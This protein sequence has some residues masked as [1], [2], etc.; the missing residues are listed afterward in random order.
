[1]YNHFY[2]TAV[3]ETGHDILRAWVARMLMLGLHITGKVPFKTIFLH[4]LVRDKHGQKMSKSKGNVVN[5]LEVIQTY[6]AD[7]LRASLMFETKEGSDVV[8]T[9]EKMIGMRN[10]GNKLWNIGRFIFMNKVDSRQSVVEIQERKTGS[11]TLK[12]KNKTLIK[13]EKELAEVKVKYHKNMD[14]YKFGQVLGDLYAFVWHRFADIYIE[15]LKEE[16]KKGNSEVLGSFEKTFLECI[17]MLHP[18]IP[19]ETEALWQVFK[20]EGESILASKL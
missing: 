13:L 3:M 15:E 17:T 11:L 10:F 14:G 5:P 8:L 1:M 19:F 4:G 20:G 16:L 6:G 12:T 9:D 18:F 7:V 2:P